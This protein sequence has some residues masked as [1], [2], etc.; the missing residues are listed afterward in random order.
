MRSEIFFFRTRS[1]QDRRTSGA[2]SFISLLH[3]WWLHN[4]KII[5]YLPRISL[6]N[7]FIFVLVLSS[8]FTYNSQQ[9]CTL[10]SRHVMKWW[11]DCS[12]YWD[13]LNRLP[14]ADKPLTATLTAPTA[15]SCQTSGVNP[16]KS[17][18]APTSRWTQIWNATCIGMKAAVNFLSCLYC[19]NIKSDW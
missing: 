14:D 2:S 17:C 8:H 15:P 5:L 1:E 4:H 18:F 9:Q 13:G 19:K 11:G 7:E 10:A 3:F 6:T 12:R 16:L